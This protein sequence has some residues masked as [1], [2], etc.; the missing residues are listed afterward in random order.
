MKFTTNKGLRRIDHKTMND[1]P[2]CGCL[3]Y[4]KK[5]GKKHGVANKKNSTGSN[6]V[7]W[8]EEKK[9]RKKW[10]E[11]RYRW[12]LVESPDC[13]QGSHYEADLLI[14]LHASTVMA[15]FW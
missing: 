4:V 2:V 11:T 5:T 1:R 15:T 8:H 6:S 7:F 14:A 9:L 3:T 13:L 12:M 10:K